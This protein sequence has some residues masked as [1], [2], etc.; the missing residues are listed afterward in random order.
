MAQA[1]RPHETQHPTQP[2]SQAGGS[3]QKDQQSSQGQ[4]QQEQQGGGGQPPQPGFPGSQR[5]GKQPGQ[6]MKD[7]GPVPERPG[8]I[9]P[10]PGERQSV[11][12]NQPGQQIVGQP[13]KEGHEEDRQHLRGRI[14]QEGQSAEDKEPKPKGVPK[15]AIAAG[16]MGTEKPDAPPL[17][18]QKPQGEEGN[19]DGEGGE[20]GEEEGKESKGQQSQQHPQAAMH[21]T[22]R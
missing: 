10:Y 5:S 13:A 2:A 22:R 19:G 4:D 6:G 17:P 18:K 12:E 8:M 9:R 1:P 7:P 20:G 11:F 21:Q 15:G 16:K 14:I 3:Q